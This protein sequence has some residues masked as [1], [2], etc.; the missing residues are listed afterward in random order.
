MHMR[1]GWVENLKP[2]IAFGPNTTLTL[3]ILLRESTHNSHSQQTK[4]KIFSLVKSE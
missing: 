4:L 3:Y 2:S 1:G